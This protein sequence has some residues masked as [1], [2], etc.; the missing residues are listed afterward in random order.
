MSEYETGL[1]SPGDDDDRRQNHPWRP[2][3]NADSNAGGDYGNGFRDGKG[4]LEIA[5]GGEFFQHVW[6]YE[7]THAAMV[8]TE[9][10]AGP[11]DFT[12]GFI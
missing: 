8:V 2:E 5:Q 7:P 12:H 11:G 10:L 9:F 4:R 6:W 1:L 3:V